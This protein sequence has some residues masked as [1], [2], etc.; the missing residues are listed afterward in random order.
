MGAIVPESLKPCPL[1]EEFMLN[2]QKL[3]RFG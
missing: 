1:P 2:N 3:A